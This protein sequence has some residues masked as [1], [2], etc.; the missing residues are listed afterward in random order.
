MR[1]SYIL[2]ILGVWVTVLS[3]LGFTHSLKDILFTITGIGLIG[4]SYMLYIEF[5][6]K[7]IKTEKTFDNFRENKFQSEEEKN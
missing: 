2:L 5:K 6:K 4:L 7:E 1:K 3:Y